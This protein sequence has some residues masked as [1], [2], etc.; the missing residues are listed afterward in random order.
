MCTLE[1]SKQTCY[2]SNLDGR[3]DSNTWSQARV[4]G[5]VVDVVSKQ[6]L[7]ALNHRK[8]EKP[9]VVIGFT[10]RL[11]RLHKVTPFRINIAR[12]RQQVKGAFENFNFRRSLF[13]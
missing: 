8:R 4:P 5:K 7:A 13:R 11:S 1:L 10:K 3:Y 9:G 6:T 2:P 12:V